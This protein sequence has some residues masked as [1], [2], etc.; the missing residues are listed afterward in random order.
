MLQKVEKIKEELGLDPKLNI[1]KG[2]QEA[3]VSLGI[4]GSGTLHMQVERLLAELG[5]NDK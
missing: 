2:V 1:A 3:N 5:I 4:E